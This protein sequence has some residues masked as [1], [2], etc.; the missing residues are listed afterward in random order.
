MASPKNIRGTKNRVALEAA[1]KRR[2]RYI[3]AQTGDVDP[4]L[5]WAAPTMT[6]RLSRCIACSC[7]D[8]AACLDQKTMLPCS[9]LVVDRTAGVGVCSSCP[10]GIKQ[11]N[12]G[13]RTPAALQKPTLESQQGSQPVSK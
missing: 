8:L 6:P 2:L 7:H 13:C 3:R 10:S 9:W 12:E 1:K 5:S 4:L 11:W